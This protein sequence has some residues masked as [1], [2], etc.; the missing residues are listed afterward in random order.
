MNSLEQETSTSELY[1]LVERHRIE[2]AIDSHIAAISHLIY[3]NKTWGV[4]A[5]I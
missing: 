2:P 4:K 1:Q 3:Q 5:N